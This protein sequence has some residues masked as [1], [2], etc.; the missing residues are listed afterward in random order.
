MYIKNLLFAGLALPALT[1]SFVI[2]SEG[3]QEAFSQ[4]ASIPSYEMVGDMALNRVDRGR[5][6]AK[7]ICLKFDS[8]KT[9]KTTAIGHIPKDFSG[10]TFS[11]QFSVLNIPDAKGKLPLSNQNSAV[12]LPNALI[13][14]RYNPDN[15]GGKSPASVGTDEGTFDLFGF[16]LHPIDS[17]PP[18]VN[19]YVIGYNSNGAEE[20]SY[21]FL[22]LLTCPPWDGLKKVEIWGTYGE[23]GDDW[24]FFVDDLWLR[25]LIWGNETA[26]Q[27]SN[28]EEEF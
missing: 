11:P 20:F 10:L 22:F 12:S 14:S 3:L 5:W 17:P 6:P 15:K 9:N 21:G 27:A 1:V 18:G 4:P 25:A 7:V 8:I 26:P 16:Y 13:G 19:I 28:N 2:P 23:D 24:E